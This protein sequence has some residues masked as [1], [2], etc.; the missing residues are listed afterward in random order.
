MAM[1]KITYST[2]RK[3][4]SPSKEEVNA[5][6]N[7]IYGKYSRL[8][9]YVSYD[10]LKS[11][12]EAKDIVN[13]TFLRMFERRR[14]F[15]S[16]QGLKYFLLVTAKNLSF[17]RYRKR[18]AEVAYSEEESE[19][20]PEGRENLYLSQFKDILDEKEYRYVVLH[21]LYGF[22]FREIAKTDGLS[23]SQVSSKY[24]RGVAKLRSYYG[25]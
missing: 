11:E 25:G 13:E 24:R 22:S 14:N 19:G 8:V 10:I 2:L 17:D 12:E 15:Q 18:K 9:Y 16:E 3:L 7:L 5:S 23:T 1:E 6:F 21:L 20:H 4:C